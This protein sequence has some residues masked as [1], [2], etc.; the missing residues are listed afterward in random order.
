MKKYI[1]IFTFTWHDYFTSLG[2]LNNALL[3]NIG[4]LKRIKTANID[5]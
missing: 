3:C 5:P 1:F 4:P 2:I